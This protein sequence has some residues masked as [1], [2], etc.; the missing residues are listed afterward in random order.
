MLMTALFIAEAIL[1]LAL[2]P[3]V[4]G[5]LFTWSTLAVSWSAFGSRTC[6]C[7][8]VANVAS[9]L[10]VLM[11]A[12]RIAEGHRPQERGHACWIWAAETPANQK[13]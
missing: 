1:L 6:T 10:A 8:A 13:S 2:S 12:S 5:S 7:G 4:D 9:L 3:P 11:T